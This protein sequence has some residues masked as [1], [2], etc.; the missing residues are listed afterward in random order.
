MLGF[1]KVAGGYV[2]FA[3][4]L[5][6]VLLYTWWR[7]LFMHVLPHNAARFTK[8]ISKRAQAGD[9]ILTRSEG[10][11]CRGTGVI[12]RFV[13]EKSPVWGRQWLR[14]VGGV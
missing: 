1:L 3:I 14:R 11:W 13:L 12:A 9:V 5:L 8:E 7:Y 6:L 2:F 4:S 10:L